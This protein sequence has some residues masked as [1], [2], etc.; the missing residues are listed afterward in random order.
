MALPFSFYPRQV[1]RTPRLS[2]RLQISGLKLEDLVSDASLMEAIF[3]AS[4][5]LHAQLTKYAEGLIG[6]EKEARKLFQSVTKYLIRMSSRCTP[7]G[8]FSGCSVVSWN[9]G[10]TNV[11]RDDR[12]Q[13]RHTRF[14]MHYLCA[15]SQELAKW[16]GISEQLVY[17]PNSSIYEYGNEIRYVEYKYSNG[18]RRHTISAVPRTEYLQYILQESARGLVRSEIIAHLVNDEIGEEEAAAFVDELLEAQLLVSEL[19]PAIT[20]PE[21]FYYYYSFS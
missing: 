6:S 14:D 3:L 19:E 10:A 7:F 11:V 5:S 4:P 8:L 2:L 13:D 1:L 12:S 21:F 9:E 20:G 15:L 17:Y 18:R 16:P